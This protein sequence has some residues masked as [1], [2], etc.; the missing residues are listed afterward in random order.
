[1]SS[2]TAAADYNSLVSKLK[3]IAIHTCTHV[4]FFTD[5]AVVFLQTRKCVAVGV[6][7][8]PNAEKMNGASR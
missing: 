8:I 2:A 7:C 4:C 1:M 5:P 3:I 6:L